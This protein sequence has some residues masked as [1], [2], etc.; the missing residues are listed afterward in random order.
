[1]NVEKFYCGDPDGKAHKVV[2]L[3]IG[4]EGVARLI[5]ER[6]KVGDTWKKLICYELPT[7][8]EEWQKVDSGTVTYTNE[9]YYTV[10]AN[11][12]YEGGGIGWEDEE[13]L[14]GD[15]LDGYWIPKNEDYWEAWLLSNPQPNDD[16]TETTYDYEEYTVVEI[17]T[18]WEWVALGEEETLIVPV[19]ELPDADKGY[20]YDGEFEYNGRNFIRMR[21]PDGSLYAYT[22]EG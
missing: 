21:D 1:M 12:S 4:V 16:E 2:R 13:E 15:W 8:I 22:K 19:G 10:Y 18:E 3:Y 6:P 11:V 5:W 17:D 14:P 9:D 20:T 7:A